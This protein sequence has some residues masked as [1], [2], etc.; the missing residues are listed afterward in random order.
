MWTVLMKSNF[1]WRSTILRQNIGLSVFEPKY[2]DEIKSELKY[3]LSLLNSVSLLI[4]TKQNVI[5]DK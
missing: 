5:N 4:E 3:E 2:Q 1:R